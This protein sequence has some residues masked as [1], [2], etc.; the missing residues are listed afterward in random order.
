MSSLSHIFAHLTMTSLQIISLLIQND[1][2]KTASQPFQHIVKKA[3]E[4]NK[5]IFH[6]STTDIPPFFLILINRLIL[7]NF[8]PKNHSFGMVE[9]RWIF[10]GKSIYSEQ[11]IF[12]G[13]CG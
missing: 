8:Q 9:C 3:A 2:S 1:L 11:F 7:L 12:E 4:K 5:A 6:L 10:G 13:F